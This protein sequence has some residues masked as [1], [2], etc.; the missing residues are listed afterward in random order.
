MTALPNTR[1]GIVVGSFFLIIFVVFFWPLLSGREVL[2]YRDAFTIGM[3]IKWFY[4]Q[5]FTWR[6]AL[7]NPFLGLGYP[8]FAAPHHAL[9]YPLQMI[10]LLGDFVGAFHRY[11]LLH[12]LLACFFMYALLRALAASRAA[13]VVGAVSFAYSGYLI[14]TIHGVNLYATPVWTP[15][16]FFAFV[17][18]F[19]TGARRWMA[20]AAVAAALQ[21]LSGEPHFAFFSFALLVCFSLTLKKPA[22]NIPL[23]GFGLGLGVLIAAVQ[24]IPALEFVAQSTRAQG[25]GYEEATLWS[26]CPVRIVEFVLP[27]F[28][29]SLSPSPDFY[30]GKFLYAQL[31]DQPIISS[32]YLGV[33][34]V[35]GLIA[36][37]HSR[38]RFWALAG[39]A[40]LVLAFGKYLPGYGLLR[41]IPPISLM[42]YPERWLL[43][44]T[45]CFAVGGALACDEIFARPKK[46]WPVLIGA[47]ALVAIAL[48]TL[49]LWRLQHAPA[50]L[51]IYKSLMHTLSVLTALGLC[52]FAM[53]SAKRRN[54]FRWGMVV[55]AAVDVLS[56]NRGILY[57]APADLYRGKPQ[58]LGVIDDPK[59]FRYARSPAFFNRLLLK[60][61]PGENPIVTN[62]RSS[63]LTLRPN[64]NILFGLSEARGYEGLKLFGPENFY[65]GRNYHHLLSL[66]S[67]RWLVVPSDEE[68]PPD[69]VHRF[70]DPEHGF[71]VYE[72]IHAL[73]RVYFA[74]D[75]SIES[76]ATAALRR[77]ATK[78]FPIER[79]II[80]QDATFAS[81]GGERLAP[82]VLQTLAPEEVVIRTDA[83][84]AGVLVLNDYAYP[85]WEV[86]VD[87]H[88]TRLLLV[89]GYARG[90]AVPAG[91]HQIA[92]RLHSRTLQWGCVVSAFGIV[93]TAVAM[94]L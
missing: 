67:A 12:Y 94:F 1:R 8:S 64:F 15:L 40:G 84:K 69:G 27:L 2:F 75:V 34:P 46:F 10:V 23:L 43:V 79:E 56:V 63:Q 74:R 22:K 80:L 6:P 31:H 54:I 49:P 36:F 52:L 3:P 14:S 45:F 29:G 53:R 4:R 24:L 9:F 30:W 70:A 25:M 26:Y 28:F 72:N 19:K 65:N 51:V 68:K 86:Y 78:D 20:L 61:L 48:L 42:R 32:A 11:V 66:L 55:I 7:W 13:A 38:A 92:F 50:A 41:L 58:W 33:L 85:G 16:V 89:N 77:V 59:T 37:G 76:D 82:P 73:P 71:E 62:V 90:V 81:I 88:P 83:E 57:T 87:E 91:A 18:T 21:I 60:P 35:L 44:P 5:T 39:T 17:R 47:L 93:L